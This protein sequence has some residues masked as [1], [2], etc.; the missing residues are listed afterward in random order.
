METFRPVKMTKPKMSE[1]T[2]KLVRIDPKF[3]ATV[4]A[5]PLCDIGMRKPKYSHF[6]TLVHSI[7]SQQLATRAAATISERLIAL[8][9]N[10]VS[11]KKMLKLGKV[12]IRKCGVSDA[13]AR[14][15][16]DLAEHT[17]NGA[18]K[19]KQFSKLPNAEIE[20]ELVRVWGIGKWT[21]QMFLMFHLGRLDIWPVDDLGVRRGWEKLHNLRTEI[22][23]KKLLKEGEKFAGFESVVA[24]YCW[25]VVDN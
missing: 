4:K 13:K 12:K 5:S 2:R 17:Q 1:L 15:I 16:L 8:S 22:T 25:R 11:A 21:A 23:P 6:E 24:W 18:I 9:A 7:I 3:K 20:A 14:A 10:D 19:F